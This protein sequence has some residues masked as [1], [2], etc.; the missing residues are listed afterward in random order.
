M[1]KLEQMN[2]CMRMSV[3]K[4][5]CVDCTPRKKVNR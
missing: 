2:V 1:D 3:K 4:C 5:V